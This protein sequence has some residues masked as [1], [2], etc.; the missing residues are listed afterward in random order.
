MDA[1][2]CTHI[3]NPDYQEYSQRIFSRK[4]LDIVFNIRD[5][6]LFYPALQEG[7]KNHSPFFLSL[8][9]HDY[10]L[11]HYSHAGFFRAVFRY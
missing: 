1:A 4:R 3:D 10:C 7:L 5:Q 2:R 6:Y 9:Y 8:C 11:S